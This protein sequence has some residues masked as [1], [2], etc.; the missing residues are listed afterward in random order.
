MLLTL[1]LL[2]AEAAQLRAILDLGPEGIVGPNVRVEHARVIDGDL[3]SVA[4]DVRVVSATGEV[5]ATAALAPLTGWRAVV[6]PEG[7]DAAPHPTTRIRI[8]APWPEGA[9]A[10]QIGGRTL[11]VDLDERAWLVAPEPAEPIHVSG[12]SARRLDLVILGDGFTEAEHAKFDEAV[13]AVTSHLARLEPYNVYGDLLNVW[14]V[15]TPSDVSGVDPRPTPGSNG[16]FDTPFE[17]Y[18]AC[19]DIDR[20]VCCDETKILP[21]VQASV[22]F[23]EGV[24]V[25]VNSN[26]YGGSGGYDYSAAFIGAEGARVAA[27]ELAHSLVLLWDEYSYGTEG[28]PDAFISHNCAPE[29]EPVPWTAWMDAAHPEIGTYPG[30]SFTNWVRPT[31]SGCMMMSLQDQY[32]PVCREHL[33]R[34]MYEAVGGPIES[35]DPSPDER[36]TLHAGDHQTFTVTSFEPRTGLEWEWSLD[37]EVVSNT[38]ETFDLDGCGNHRELQLTVRDPTPWVRSD[39]EGWLESDVRWKIKTDRCEGDPARCGCQT[40]PAPAGLLALAALALARRRR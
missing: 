1:S 2:T 30:C 6:T 31:P 4:G 25:L 36:L 5:L 7:H 12:L 9:Y 23:A 21:Q 8:A 15:F 18:Y 14:K 38:P 33:V 29:G 13:A 28:D 26:V 37:G 39:P 17:C 3:R 35:V 11:P 19:N 32:C 10:L 20:L 22:P 16:A 27:H 40:G 34:T 24:L